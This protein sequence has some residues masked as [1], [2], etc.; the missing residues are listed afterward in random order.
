MAATYPIIKD[1]PP[2]DPAPSLDTAKIKASLA[3]LDVGAAFVIP[4]IE[5]HVDGV[6]RSTPY[7]QRIHALA[8]I[9]GVRVST[10]KVAEGLRVRREK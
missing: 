1:L 5:M 2:D 8:R 9:M 4:S 10:K 7:G 6:F 3:R